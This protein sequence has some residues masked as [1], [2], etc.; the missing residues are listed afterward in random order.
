MLVLSTSSPILLLCS[1]SAHFWGFPDVILLP[2]LTGNHGGFQ[3]ILRAPADF[4]Y[5]IPE[6]LDSVSAAPLLCAGVTVYAPLRR[7]A[8]TVPAPALQLP[9]AV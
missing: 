7:C 4:T 3:D 9:F 1:C 2:F 6:G 8:A 5:I